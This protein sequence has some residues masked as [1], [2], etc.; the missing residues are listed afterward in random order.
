MKQIRNIAIIAHVDHGKTTLVDQLLRQSGTFRA[1]QQVDE[2]V[3]DSNDLE[4]ERGITILAKNTAIDYEGCH[5]NIVDTPGHADFGGEVERVLGMV[6]CVVLLVDA[7]EGP[8]PQ[9]RFVTKKALALGLKPIVVINKIDKPSARPSWV[10]DQTF[11]LFDNLGATDE[12]LDFPIVYASGLS[13]FA[14][15]EETDES[16]D[17]RPLFDTILKY[18]PAP[19]GSADEPLQLQISQLDYDN[20]TGRLGIGRILNGRIKP[21]QTVAV[22]NHEQQIS[23]GRINQLLGFKGLER[24]PLEEAEAGDIVIISGI[25]D[26]GIGVTITDK[27]NPKGLP[28]LRVDE[29]TLTMD[30]MVNTSPLAGTEGKFVT[31][32][33]IRDRLQKEL[34]TNVALR[35]E[36]TADADVFRVSGRGELHLTILLENMRREGYELAVGKPRVVYRDIDGQK[37]E[38]YENLTVDVPDDN[39]G[40]V[41]EELGRRRGELTNM[42]SDG[43]GRTRLEY[44]IP[45]RGLIGF[46]GEFMTLTRGVGLMSHVFDDYAPVKPDMP[47]RHNGVLVSQEQGEAVAYALWNLEDRGRMFVSPNDKIYEGMIIGI[48][49]R[50][51]DLV[52]NPLKGKK[53][54]NIRASGTDEAVRL[55]T[56]IKLT[57]EGA[58]E[59]IDDDELVEITPQSI[60]LRKRYLSE[61][62]RR[63]HFKKLD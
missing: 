48:H 21:G 7:Q 59:F 43:N 63:R 22:M 25:E 18:T 36:D 20:Y 58:V 29:P 8:M 42:E 5:I 38:P 9:T 1:N 49:S 44:H 31:S 47:G 46:Q 24:V 56:P 45:A 13:G 12:Q 51:N 17:M 26:I 3:M 11:E 61:L 60:R 40:A 16:S 27:D 15:L 62:E 37:C 6:D 55:T 4:K 34:L 30:F 19:S 57:L 2:R 39:Q 14:K 10:I 50:D 33:Q 41:M 32:R 53:L 35:V 54:T 23:Q 52:V 28:M